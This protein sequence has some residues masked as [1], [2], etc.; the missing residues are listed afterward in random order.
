MNDVAR[1]PGYAEL[2][3][4]QPLETQVYEQYY[5][6]RAQSSKT[7]TTG[8]TN[9]TRGTY[10]TGET[11]F[12]D[13]LGNSA[14]TET[15]RQSQ[16]LNGD[17]QHTEHS[18]GE[19]D[20]SS[21]DESEDELAIDSQNKTSP[22][23]MPVTPF[24]VGK[25][26]NH[27]G[28]ILDS[29]ERTPA[30]DYSMM[31]PG[32]QSKGI[33][34][35]SQVFHNTQANSTMPSP[36][37]LLSDPIF[38]RPS[39]PI[40]DRAQRST[41]ALTMSSPALAP[42][43]DPTRS[44]TEPRSAY[45]PIDESQEQRD[46]RRRQGEILS[47]PT[48][49][50]GDIQWEDDSEEK[51][52]EAKLRRAQ[53][54]KDA[55]RGFNE[56]RAPPNPRYGSTKRR[57]A[58]SETVIGLVST[59]RRTPVRNGKE[60]IE[61]SS[62]HGDQDP[63]DSSDSQ[64][65]YDEL[66]QAVIP[67]ERSEVDETSP[68]EQVI[69][70]S[71]R[72]FLYIVRP[73][74]S[75]IRGRYGGA[76]KRN[77][78]A[79]RP[80]SDVEHHT[81]YELRSP[82]RPQ[83]VVKRP[84]AMVANS[85]PGDEAQDSPVPPRPVLPSSIDSRLFISQSQYASLSSNTRTMVVEFPPDDDA[86]NTSS[87]PPA[88]H[89]DSSQPDVEDA[90]EDQAQSP[91]NSPFRIRSSSKLA[92][93]VGAN[94][95]EQ[96]RR[97]ETDRRNTDGSP[98]A[99]NVIEDDP[100]RQNQ[101]QPVLTPA[102]QASRRTLSHTIPE[103]SPAAILEPEPVASPRRSTRRNHTRDESSFEPASQ[104][105][106]LEELP[107]ASHGPTQFQTARTQPS[108]PLS[109]SFNKNRTPTA[110]RVS[111]KLSP[112]IIRLKHMSDIA[113]EPSPP[114]P[115]RTVDLENVNIMGT[116][117]MEFH[118]AISGTS[119]NARPSKRPR[120]RYGKTSPKSQAK[121]T[122]I[123]PQSSPPVVANPAYAESQSATTTNQ[124]IG[125]SF[126]V[127]PLRK[128]K[129]K[130]PGMTGK[131]GFPGQ[132]PSS[133]NEAR[134]VQTRGPEVAETPQTPR[135]QHFPSQASTRS[136]RHA[137][138]RAQV[139]AA[140][141]AESSSPLSSPPPS[142]PQP[143]A[144]DTSVAS[145]V[146]AIQ[147]EDGIRVPNRV[148][149]CFRGVG[150]G[151][152]FYPAT[153]LGLA[154]PTSLSYQVRFDDGTVDIIEPHLVKSLDLQLGDLVKVDA[155]GMRSKTY[156][157]TGYKESWDGNE[158]G[159]GEN[160]KT[161]IRGYISVTLEPK[162]RD[163]LPQA[164]RVQ[165]PQPVNVPVTDLYITNTLWARFEQRGTDGP[166][167]YQDPEPRLHT[168]LQVSTPST[169]SSR[170]RRH[171]L[172]SAAQST[173]NLADVFTAN[174]GGIFSNMAFAIS[175]DATWDRERSLVT[176]LIQDNGGQVLT[177]GFEQLFESVGSKLTSPSKPRPTATDDDAQDLRLSPAFQNLSFVAL[178][179][180]A[181][182]RRTKYMQALAL[183]IPC[184][185]GRWISDCID[186]DHLIPWMTYLLPAGE[187]AFL[188]GAIRS[189]V[190]AGPSDG[191]ATV[192]QTHDTISRRPKLLADLGIILM[193]GTGKGTQGDRGNAFVFLTHALG[194]RRIAKAK[195]VAAVRSLIR[196]QG[197]WD[198]ICV[199]DE[200]VAEVKRELAKSGIAPAVTPKMGASKRKRSGGADGAAK[201]AKGC[202]VVG[203]EFLVQ[204]LVLG[205]LVEE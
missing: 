70:K 46:L 31:F 42:R 116:Q 68:K 20:V 78:R 52:L 64:D 94:H 39:P 201:G 197:E 177:E 35:L 32:M 123:S 115:S 163:S 205:A 141:A 194:A 95:V 170:T 40:F 74:S 196:N 29:V 45:Q 157:V 147:T 7:N 138:P 119:Y 112:H 132:G 6:S 178:V 56:L 16:Q 192:M 10:A 90:A 117:E 69:P 87:I 168:P 66:S 121:V 55:S 161:D 124:P 137:T 62:D 97:E 135:R 127:M 37:N 81:G 51:R 17:T 33:V 18:D 105:P 47:S 195:D 43:P 24:N 179:A 15:A 184:L 48:G 150:T 114:N 191:T 145:R 185:A 96:T 86:L 106:L 28:N 60:V 140:T 113:A 148:L 202:R 1:N 67:S 44:I 158:P 198:F 167:M 188:E 122:D 98:D 156:R 153:C 203:N 187:S 30:P 77:L 180:N 14:A 4:T 5:S 100:P 108:E 107:V 154:A 155:Q 193:S 99:V 118:T 129:L 11:G 143:L 3:P 2:G 88:P 172:T 63:D 75:P 190:L 131:V 50:N 13:L 173:T 22:Q 166:P 54:R 149:A 12:V 25:K 111:G 200:R 146:S 26:R 19:Q 134:N 101:A 41:P 91:S 189:R 159:E 92:G 139:L 85:Q 49:G 186:K 80:F 102:Q 71:A 136:L 8:P 120:R 174:K 103:T 76:D 23:M 128:G 182:S 93:K 142:D 183:N 199:E 84:A 164:D 181:H 73:T 109:S 89:V 175:Y 176:K 21:A 83:T 152:T 162:A 133:D 53:D 171:N 130:R 82:Q 151:P 61:I 204:S 165:A 79:S 59:K 34:G 57:L 36:A 160:V 104:N 72:K 9:A 169:P 58:P 27:N 144:I 38:D 110:D 125:K 126:Q 65:M